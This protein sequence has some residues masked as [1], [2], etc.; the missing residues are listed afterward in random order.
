MGSSEASGDRG[1]AGAAATL[2]R[3]RGQQTGKRRYMVMEALLNPAKQE[4]AA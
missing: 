2:L 3:H 1:A 4:V